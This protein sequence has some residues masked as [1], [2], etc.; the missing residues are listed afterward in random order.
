MTLQRIAF[1]T[2]FLLLVVTLGG[3]D[4]LDENEPDDPAPSTAGVLVANQGNFGDGNGSVTFY[5]LATE[6]SSEVIQDIGSIIQSLS[7]V[8]D[9]LYVAA[10]TGDRVSS[11]SLNDFSQTGQAEVP[12]PRYLAQTGPSEAYVTS[13]TWERDP[14]VRILDLTQDTV[15]DSLA[16]EGA[17]E[18]LTASGER[19]YVA[20]GGFEMAT[21]LEVVDLSARELLD[22]IDIGCYARIVIT[23]RDDEVFAFCNTEEGEGEA[24]VLDGESGSVADRLELS[25]SVSSADPGKDAYFDPETEEAYVVLDQERVARINTT[26]NEVVEVLGPFDGAPIGAVAYDPVDETLYLGRVP[27]FDEA[28]TVTIHERDGTE[29]GS[30]QAGVAPTDITLLYGHE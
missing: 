11:F 22:P 12:S 8:E 21:H 10:N 9:R 30:F 4:L 7:V 20:A 16:V 26:S 18:G 24:V 17:P 2:A 1:L 23:D 29:A 5:D 13:Q 14:S 3:C 28:G 19:L 6:E 15:V 27:G 25:G